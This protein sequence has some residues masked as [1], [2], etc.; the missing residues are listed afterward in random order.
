M[1]PNQRELIRL[2]N[3]DDRLPP[4]LWWII[5]EISGLVRSGSHYLFWEIH[6]PRFVFSKDF[7]KWQ[8]RRRDP[9]G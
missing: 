6:V 4:E 9:P 2:Y 1:K 5:L 7:H 8:R 3:L